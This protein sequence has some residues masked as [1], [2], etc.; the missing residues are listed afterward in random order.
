MDAALK[1]LTVQTRELANGLRLFAVRVPHVQRAVVTAQLNVG[2][3]FETRSTHGLSHFLE[4][5][6]YRGTEAHPTAHALVSAIE[7]Q[8]GYLDAMT[9]ADHGVLSLS[10]PNQSLA[11]LIPIFAEV[12][13]RPR[14]GEDD[15]HSIEIERG[16]V[17]EELLEELDARDR[18]V[19]PDNL[20]KRLVFGD[21]PLGLSI[22]GNLPRLERFDARAL[23]KHHQRHYAARNSV[24]GVVSALAPKRMLDTLESAFH[25]L[26]SG[27]ALSPPAAPNTPVKAWLHVPH[28]ISQTSVRLCFRGVSSKNKLEPATQLLLR[29]LDDGMSTRLYAR[30][31]DELGLCYE[32]SA[33]Y[34]GYASAGVLDLAAD[35]Q[36]EKLRV[37]VAELLSLVE[38]LRTRGPSKEELELAKRRHAWQLAASSESAEDLA[39]VLGF[40]LLSQGELAPQPLAAR[41]AALQQVSLKQVRA[42][43]RANLDPAQG[44]LVTV[45][46]LGR[47]DRA[48]IQRLLADTQ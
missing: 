22:T 33:Q 16:I 2:P 39:E 14:L 37:V 32:V 31:C 36:H 42:A 12:F 7:R 27:T 28:E 13:Q 47:G 30:L 38:E 9:Y 21:H 19:E 24:V 1:R 45:G 4:H 29:T 41:Q 3:H 44:G 8:G 46:Q 40:D 5:M 26:N 10:A 43:A 17:R 23:R 34:E 6:L 18:Q 20:V 48:E 11:A 35:A 25:E 15:P